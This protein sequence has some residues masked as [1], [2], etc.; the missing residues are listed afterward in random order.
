MTRANPNATQRRLAFPSASRTP[1]LARSGRTLT[2]E[3]PL[4]IRT[5]GLPATG[6]ARAY[7]LQRAGFKFGKFA[8]DIQGV[9]VRFK[10]ESGPKGQP[11]VA[12]TLT[13]PLV[14][15]GLVVVERAA[16]QIFA[17]FDTAV[18]VAERSVRRTLQRLRDKPLR[19]VPEKRMPA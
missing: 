16:D 6:Q 12:C 2:A 4:R 15:G 19:K 18:D 11:L 17:A 13:L 10:D 7:V 3:T 1:K 8:L 14:R 9:E 5:F